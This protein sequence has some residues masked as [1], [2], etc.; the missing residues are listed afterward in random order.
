MVL[1]AV[2][3]SVSKILAMPLMNSLTNGIF[4]QVLKIAEAIP[5]YKAAYEDDLTYYRS[6]NMLSIFSKIFEKLIFIQYTLQFLPKQ[7]IPSNRP[8]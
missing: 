2:I 4:S 1:L 8:K 6:I 3:K 7:I 5:I